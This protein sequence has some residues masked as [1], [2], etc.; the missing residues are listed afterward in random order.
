MIKYKNLLLLL[1]FIAH[2]NMHGQNDSIASTKVNKKENRTSY[3][4]EAGSYGTKRE[5][6]PQSY[7][8]NYSEINGDK[9]SKSNWLN[10]GLYTRTRAEWRHNDIRRTD[11]Y[12]NDYPLL[13]KTRAYI[14]I[15]NILDPIRGSIEFGDSR[16]NNGLYPE[17]NRDVNTTDIIQAYAE[18]YFDKILPRDKLGNKRPTFLR[19]GRMAMEMIDRRLIATNQWRNTTNNF[20]GFRMQIGQDKNDWQ[21]DFLFLNPILRDINDYDKPDTNQEFSAIIGHWRKWSNIITIEPYY[22]SLKQEA[23]IANGNK[24]RNIHSL[25]LRLYGWIKNTGF[26]YDIT[27]IHQFGTDN[28]KTQKAY[29]ATAEIGYTFQKT[30]YKPRL[31]A[32]IGY[33]SGDKNPNDNESNRF[34]RFFGFARPW[35]AD[36]YIIMENI[37]APKIKLE[38]QSKIKNT[39]V[40]VDTGYNFYWLANKKDRFNNLLGGTTNNRDLTGQSGSFLGHN[41]DCRIRFIPVKY[42][43]TNIGYSHFITEEFVQNQQIAQ[44]GNYASNSDFVYLELTFNFL[45][46]IKKTK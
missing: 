4:I 14:G 21:M 33:A 13:F 3:Y 44:N 7:V 43:E 12:S 1:C 2:T 42:L 29:A 45:E 41:F 22:L 31:S 9:S 32:F 27:G 24:S 6:E 46:L 23:A 35:S 10:L 37:I 30:K 19:Y 8:L 36:D 17:D 5:T 39:L 34:E 11:T 15:I 26:N 38:F 18:L 20:K 16:R 40:K 28:N 25:G